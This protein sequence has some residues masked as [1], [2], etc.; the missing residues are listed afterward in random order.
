MTLLLFARLMHCWHGFTLQSARLE[1]QWRLIV[2]KQSA[3]DEVK[4]SLL[5]CC[6]VAVLLLQGSGRPWQQQ[7]L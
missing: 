2:Q 3:A 6:V 7:H 5:A 1:S 4:C